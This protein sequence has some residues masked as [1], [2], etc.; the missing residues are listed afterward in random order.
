MALWSYK[1]G[2]SS[3][4]WDLF[5]FGIQG[6]G[7]CIIGFL[8][9]FSVHPTVDTNWMLVL[10]NPLPLFYLPVMIYKAVKHKKDVYHW[11]NAI[12]LVVFILSI[13][14]LP[15]KVNLVVLPFALSLLVCSVGHLLVY[16]KKS[17]K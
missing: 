7:G 5:L 16:Y 9:F 2:K 14:F 13:P 11:I 12:G 3:W 1:T 15:Q 6:I 17:F 10:F 8:F 4:L